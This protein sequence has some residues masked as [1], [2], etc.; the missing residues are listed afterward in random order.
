MNWLKENIAIAIINAI[1]VII[2]GVTGYMWQDHVKR[3]DAQFA[4]HQENLDKAFEA[5]TSERKER[6]VADER[7]NLLID[8][9]VSYRE[10]EKLNAIVI[11]INSDV[12]D[13]L[14]NQ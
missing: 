1:F 7:L 14:K 11:E 4:Q 9:K 10:F 5:I 6:E 3:Q 12:K 8:N 13:I 2:M